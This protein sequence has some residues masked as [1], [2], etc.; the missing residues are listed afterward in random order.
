MRKEG[1][2][3]EETRAG[4]ATLRRGEREMGKGGL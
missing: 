1:V 2:G 3:W 4:A